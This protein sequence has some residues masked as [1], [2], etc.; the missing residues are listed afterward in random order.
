MTNNAKQTLHSQ[1]NFAHATLKFVPFY[2]M[3]GRQPGCLEGGGRHGEEGGGAATGPPVQWG[4]LAAGRVPRPLAVGAP[5][6]S[7]PGP[8]GWGP[9]METAALA[10]RRRGTLGREGEG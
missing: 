5:G 9:A 7:G 3:E 10:G 6:G 1:H 2:K 4:G 8:P